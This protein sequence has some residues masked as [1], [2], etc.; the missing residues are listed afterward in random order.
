MLLLCSP[1]VFK[2][3]KEI[4]LIKGNLNGGERMNALKWSLTFFVLFSFFSKRKKKIDIRE[5]RVFFFL[6]RTYYIMDLKNNNKQ[7]MP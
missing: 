2:L 3:L 1:P 7:N 5:V 6:T 4:F